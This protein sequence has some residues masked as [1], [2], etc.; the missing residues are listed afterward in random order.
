[1]SLLRIIIFAA[2]GYFIFKTIKRFLLGAQT[3]AHEK[4]HDKK[5][6]ENIQDKYADN[7]EDADFE[8]L[9]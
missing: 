3:K 7:I 9:E 8:E 5:S 4:K 2:L 1:M 6:E